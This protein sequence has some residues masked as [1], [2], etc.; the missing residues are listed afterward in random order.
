MGFLS[1]IYAQPLIHNNPDATNLIVT[2]FTILAGFLIAMMSIMGDPSMFMPG[3]W[4]I[5]VKQTPFIRARM[6]RQKYTFYFYL[7]T[8]LM[9]FLSM[10]AKKILPVLVIP[11]EHVYLGLAVT[12][13]ILSVRLPGALMDIQQERLDF[14]VDSRRSR[15]GIKPESA[16]EK[17]AG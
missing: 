16:N 11:F 4:R 3:G 1:G 14:I 12:S 2:V 6:I 7:A 13:F 8:L 10:L 5:A 15:V 9:V 17:N